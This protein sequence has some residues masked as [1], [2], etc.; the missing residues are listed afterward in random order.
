MVLSS[1]SKEIRLNQTLELK[2][3]LFGFSLEEIFNFS[4]YFGDDTYETF[5]INNQNSSDVYG[6]VNQFEIGNNEI[7]IKKKYNKTGTHSINLFSEEN[8]N[9]LRIDVLGLLGFFYYL[10]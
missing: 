10:S 7:I 2:L 8:K 4:I 5:I 3:S 6:S 9:I 1:Q